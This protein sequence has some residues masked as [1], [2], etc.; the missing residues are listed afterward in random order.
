MKIKY[1]I[2]KYIYALASFPGLRPASR[3]LQYSHH[4]TVLQATGSWVKAWERGYIHA[5]LQNHRTMK[6]FYHENFPIYGAHMVYV[7]SS[8][9]HFHNLAY[10]QPHLLFSWASVLQMLSCLNS[11]CVVLLIA[12]SL[13]VL[14][15]MLFHSDVSVGPAPRH[16]FSSVVFCWKVQWFTLLLPIRFNLWTGHR[17]RKMLCYLCCRQ[18]PPHEFPVYNCCACD[19]HELPIPSMPAISGFTYCMNDR[20]MDRQ[21][22]RQSV[23]Q[24]DRPCQESVAPPNAWMTDGWTDRQ[25]DR[26]SVRQ[27]DHARNQWLHLMHE[28][29]TD[30]QTDRQTDHASNQWLHLPHEWQTD[31][32]TDRQTGRQSVRQT[33]RPCQES[34]ASPN[35]WMNRGRLHKICT[36]CLVNTCG[37]PR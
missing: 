37:S 1:V 18:S 15:F 32:Q 13:S 22:D 12:F 35:A 30:G 19:K 17:V 7:N 2:N 23:R 29:Q 3:R 16:L 5:T 20:R 26:Q 11:F 25:T 8:A 28:W 24:T 6:Y 31:G 21:T 9:L 27:T 10:H 14:S 4:L 34:V 33:D 36:H